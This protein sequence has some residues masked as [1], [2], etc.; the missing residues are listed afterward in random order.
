MDIRKFDVF[1]KLDKEYRVGTTYGGILSI[2]SILMTIILAYSEIHAY[3]HPSVRQRLFVDNRRPTGPDN[4]TISHLLQP[5]LPISVDF[6]FPHVPC[7]LLHFDAID[8]ITQITMPLER[9]NSSYMRLSQSGQELGLI[10]ISDLIN[11]EVNK[12]KC[13]S[14]YDGGKSKRICCRSCQEVFEVRKELMTIPPRLNE[15]EQCA[16]VF[17]K[18]MTMENE[19]C[20]IKASFNGLRTAAEFHIAPGYSFSTEDGFHIHDIGVF[21]KTFAE[22]NLTHTVNHVR[23]NEKPGRYPLDGLVNVQTERNSWRVV[24]TADIL[25]GN[26]SASKYQIYDSKSYIQGIIIKYDVSPISAREYLDKENVLH[27]CARLLTVIGGALGIFRLLDL[28]LFHARKRK[29]REE[30]EVK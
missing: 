14:C 25:E 16:P 22:I 9:I 19:G 8:S 20:R 23:F 27:L 26:F 21:N 11:T 18:T 7:Y 12:E 17:E 30:I 13:G 5:K 6:T 10:N 1:P 2:L 29:R 28:V 3:M 15:V 4:V 24:Y